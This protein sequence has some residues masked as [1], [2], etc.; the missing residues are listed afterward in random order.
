MSNRPNQMIVND[1][2][3]NSTMKTIGVS[4]I[5]A[6]MLLILGGGIAL[7]NYSGECKGYRNGFNDGQ[8]TMEMVYKNKPDF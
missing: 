7:A 4:G 6:G 2:E 5:L 1:H 3:P 8:E